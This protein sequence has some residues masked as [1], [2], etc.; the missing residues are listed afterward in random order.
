MKTEPMSIHLELNELQVC[1]LWGGIIMYEGIGSDTFDHLRVREIVVE[2]QLRYDNGLGRSVIAYYY[3]KSFFDG[4]TR[5][6]L[7]TN[8]DLGDDPMVPKNVLA[9]KSDSFKWETIN[10]IK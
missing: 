4:G 1:N 8:T 9:Y 10:N 3:P 6:S 7:D 2:M 5:Y